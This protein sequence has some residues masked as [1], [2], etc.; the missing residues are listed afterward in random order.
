MVFHQDFSFAT[1]FLL[2][3]HSIRATLSQLHS[4]SNLFLILL[5]PA[6]SLLFPC[7]WRQIQI[8]FAVTGQVCFKNSALQL[9]SLCFPILSNY[10]TAL[11]SGIRACFVP[12]VTSIFLAFSLSLKTDTVLQGSWPGFAL[13]LL[14]H[15]NSPFSILCLS[16]CL[17]VTC[18]LVSEVAESLL[19]PA[20]SLFFFTPRDRYSSARL[21]SVCSS[22]SFSLL[23]VNFLRATLWVGFPVHSL[24]SLI[25]ISLILLLP[26]FSCWFLFRRTDSVLHWL[27]PVGKT[28][29]IKLFSR[30][31]LCF[32]QVSW[33]F[34]PIE[35]F[36][37]DI[38]VQ[39]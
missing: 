2:A 30:F 8:C 17:F 35:L 16:S 5:L 23:R 36:V 25:Q 33:F 29:W 31:H 37:V 38:S 18:F 32:R 39:S 27:S 26:V 1:N 20:F 24:H 21:L 14:Y 15:Y 9:F 34:S 28:L 7:H 11:F 10:S 12:A 3:F 22:V 4:V 13:G 6:F 19:L